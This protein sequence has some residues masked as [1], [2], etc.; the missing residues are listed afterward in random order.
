MGGNKQD[1][2]GTIFELIYWI[3]ILIIAF[4]IPDAIG[5]LIVIIIICVRGLLTGK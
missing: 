3:I 2:L 4:A 5:L 1:G